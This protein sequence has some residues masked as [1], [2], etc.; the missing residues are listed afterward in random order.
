MRKKKCKAGDILT[1]ICI[2]SVAGKGLLIID[3]DTDEEAVLPIG[4]LQFTPEQSSVQRFEALSKPKIGFKSTRVTVRVIEAYIDSRFHKRILVSEQ[5]V[6]TRIY[7]RSISCT[8]EQLDLIPANTVPEETLAEARL[9]RDQ[10]RI[11]RGVV[12]GDVSGGKKI[13]VGGYVGTLYSQD[14]FVVKSL[15]SLKRGNTVKVRIKGVSAKEITLTRKD[16][17]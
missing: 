16:L 8:A 9:S 13:D 3:L 15:D 4:E 14:S 5:A 7:E 2:R 11:I 12:V 6:Q 1:G 17:A 10:K